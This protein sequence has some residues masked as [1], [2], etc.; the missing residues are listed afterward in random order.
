MPRAY[1]S[2]LQIVF[3]DPESADA[4]TRPADAPV[5]PAETSD[6]PGDE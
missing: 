2:D 4:Q 5:E 1:W 6:G 3:D